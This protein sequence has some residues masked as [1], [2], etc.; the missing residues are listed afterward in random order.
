MDGVVV[1]L[2]LRGDKNP[3]FASSRMS[4]EL[5]AW[6]GGRLTTV[7]RPVKAKKQTLS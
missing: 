2:L 5:R 1:M 7:K 3:K 6:R 4:T